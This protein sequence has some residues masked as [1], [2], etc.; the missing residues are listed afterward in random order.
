[1]RARHV[2]VFLAV[3]LMALAP[4]ALAAQENGGQRSGERADQEK[5][6]GGGQ[7]IASTGE[8]GPGDTVGFAAISTDEETDDARGRFQAVETSEAGEDMLIFHG[9]VTCLEIGEDGE[10]ARFGGHDRDD[11]N[12]KFTV[13]VTDSGPPGRSD[14]DAVMF[15]DTDEALRGGGRRRPGLLR[16]DP[17]PRQRHHPRRRQ[18]RVK[19]PVP[20]PSDGPGAHPPGPHRFEDVAPVTGATHARSVT[21][22]SAARKTPAPP[23]SLHHGHH[24]ARAPATGA[25]GRRQQ[26]RLLSGQ[27]PLA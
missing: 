21:A 23:P 13:D 17:R 1:M 4:T 14:S 22:A 15:R 20:P 10:T 26:A 12:D 2:F 18:R 11:E 6:T 24:A 25:R 8:P 5:V 9:E 19:A 27:H 3:A 7:V 16:D